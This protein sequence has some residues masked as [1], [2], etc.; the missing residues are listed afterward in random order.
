[1]TKYFLGK[2]IF[3]LNFGTRNRVTRNRR[4]ARNRSV[5]DILAPTAR[6][7]IQNRPILWFYRTRWMS[8]LAATAT[9]WSNRS[10]FSDL[11]TSK[12]RHDWENQTVLSYHKDIFWK[13][14]QFYV[15][16]FFNFFLNLTVSSHWANT[17]RWGR[18]FRRNF[19]VFCSSWPGF[20]TFSKFLKCIRNPTQEDMFVPN[21]VHIGRAI[22]STNWRQKKE[23]EKKQSNW[24]LYITAFC[25]NGNKKTDL[26]FASFE[27]YYDIIVQK[28]SAQIYQ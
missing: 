26:V 12:I 15:T 22:V 20:L 7:S 1:M 24:K 18:N 23:K 10:E 11:G 4:Q 25:K 8:P 16:Q 5:L 6:L 9:C 28:L 27:C 13:L 14:F 2:N 17:W 19:E 3:F 21:F